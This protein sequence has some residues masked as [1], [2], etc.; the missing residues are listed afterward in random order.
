RRKMRK[1]LENARP[2]RNL[3][4]AMP[5]NRGKTQMKKYNIFGIGNALVDTEFSV[6]PED[7]KKMNIEKG[8]MTL[9]DNEQRKSLLAYLQNRDG[10]QACGG[11]AANTMIGAT[12]LGSSCYYACR[13]SDDSMG[14]FY[15]D[16]LKLNKIGSNLGQTSL[17][18]GDTGL[19]IV[20]ITPDSDRTMA[21]Y[22]GITAEFNKTDIDRSALLESDILYMEGYLIASPPSKAAMFEA[23]EIAKENKIKTALTLSDP[24]MTKFFF[25][26]FMSILKKKVDLLFA[27]KDEA[28]SMCKTEDIEEAVEKFKGFAKTFVI[29][30]G[31][32]GAII[33]DGQTKHIVEGFP[34]TTVDCTGA[35]DL[36]AGAFLS[37]IAQGQ[38]FEKA[39]RQA[40]FSASRVVSSYGPRLSEQQV[41]EIKSF[42]A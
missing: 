25:D 39:G 27:N 9:I 8:V 40:S 26:D 42:F 38:S 21:T 41:Q 17:P 5:S 6:T 32:E 37:A 4:S 3:M 33:Y 29:T 28:L 20:L 16:D 36:F 2:N 11:S 23:F 34:V 35:G 24:N 18:D 13:V 7:L 1:M 30:L 15:K 22:L 31:S 19:C 10:K 14:E 12:Q